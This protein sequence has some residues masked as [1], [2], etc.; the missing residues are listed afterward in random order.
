[1]TTSANVVYE[2][3]DVINASEEFPYASKPHDYYIESK[4]LQEKVA[5][6]AL[7]HLMSGFIRGYQAVLG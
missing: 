5:Q 2:G 4:I 3:K 7:V 1:M 6:L